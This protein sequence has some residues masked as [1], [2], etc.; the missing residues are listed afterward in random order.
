[1]RSLG[2]RTLALGLILAFP[3]AFAAPGFTPEA[4]QARS[5]GGGADFIAGYDGR[6][7]L[8]LPDGRPI[9]DDRFT[10]FRYRDGTNRRVIERARHERWRPGTP[11][12][13]AIPVHQY[14]VVQTH[15]APFALLGDLQIA[16]GYRDVNAYLMPYGAAPVHD[17]PRSVARHGPVATTQPRK[18]TPPQK[19]TQP[20]K[21]TQPQKA[22][23]PRKATPPRKS[24]KVPGNTAPKKPLAWG[25]GQ[26]ASSKVQQAV[27]SAVPTQVSEDVRQ[28]V[29]KQVRLSIAMHQNG[30]RLLLA[31]VLVYGYGRIY[32][33]QIAQPLKV[34]TASAGRECFLNPGDLLGFASLPASPVAEMK[35]VASGANSCLPGELVQVHLTDLQGMLD[36]FSVRVKD[37]MTRV[38]ACAAPG[39]C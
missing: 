24:S 22:T 13:A 12:Y 21:A 35:V 19:A 9:L 25:D 14:T 6:R 4:M 26:A 39:R 31:D 34:G 20:R 10:S 1:M 29:R 30:R 33:F 2:S 15:G 17:G 36:G 27:L 3:W 11:E 37:N 38:S 28:Q 16:S 7:V 18:A 8:V 32:L 23:Q 5:V